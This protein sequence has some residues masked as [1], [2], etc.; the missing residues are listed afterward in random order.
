[1]L[2][3]NNPFAKGKTQMDIIFIIIAL[4]VMGFLITGCKMAAP[5]R[6]PITNVGHFLPDETALI[7]LT[8]VKTGTD[9]AKNKIFWEHV[10][11]VD[12]A[13]SS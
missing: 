12:A 5:F 2:S 8:Y 1:M 7:A 3:A 4:L 9:S 10:L 11:K 13:V 6:S